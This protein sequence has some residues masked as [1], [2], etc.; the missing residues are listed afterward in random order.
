MEKAQRKLRQS[1][2]IIEEKNRNIMDSIRYA[3]KIQ[4]AML[5]IKEKMAKELKDSFVIY[6]PKDIVSGD[7]YWF[8]VVEGQYFLAVADCTGHGVPGALLSMIGGMMLNEVVSEKHILDPA[9]ALSHLHQGFRSILKQEIGE[10]ETYDGMDMGLCRIDF[11]TGKITFAGAGRPLFYVKSLKLV[12]IKGDRKSI[13]GRQKEEKRFFTNHEIDILGRKQGKIMLYLTTDGF[14]D[15]HDPQ[16][17]KYGS[18]RLKK[19]LRG[20]AHLSTAQ[21]KAALL[22]ELKGHRANEEQRDD[23]TII[24]IHIPMPF[25]HF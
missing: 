7:F 8:D 3:R 15:Q 23:I 4:R 18:S 24:G 14:A 16:N 11:R 1:K 25:S 17:Q 22:E 6:E 9:M 2:K 5:P 20:N 21:Q 12:E 19:F 10:A 13:G